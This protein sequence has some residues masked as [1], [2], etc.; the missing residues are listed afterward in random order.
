M[1][2]FMLKILHQAFSDNVQKEAVVKSQLP[3]S[4]VLR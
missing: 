2:N 4:A 3:H 1:L